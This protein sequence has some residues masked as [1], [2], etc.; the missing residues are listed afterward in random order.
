MDKSEFMEGKRVEQLA[1]KKARLDQTDEI[2][3]VVSETIKEIYSK[4]YS[5]EVVD[6]FLELHNHD[7]IINDISEDNTYVIACEATILGTGTIN[8]NTITRVYITPNNQH[9][10]I[11]TKLMDYLEKEIIKNYSYVNIDASCQLLNFIANEDT[12]F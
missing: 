9:E 4:Y 11:G 7:N 10:E 5:N 8:Q 2:N 6:F 12:N 3:E 1:I